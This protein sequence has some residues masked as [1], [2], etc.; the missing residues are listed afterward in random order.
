MIRTGATFGI[1]LLVVATLLACGMTPGARKRVSLPAK[2]RPYVLVLGTAQDGGLPQIGCERDC[3]RPAWNDPSAGRL[4]SSLL[5]VDPRDGKRWLI[6]ATPD[7]REQVERA[8]GHGRP[9][10]PGHRPPLFEGVFLTH[11]H[12]GHYAGLLHLGREA[13]SSQPMRVFCSQRSAAFLGA[14]A[15]WSALVENQNI[16][17]VPIAPDAPIHLAPGLSITPILVPHRDEYSDTFAFRIEGPGSSLLFVPD[18]DK[19]ERWDTPIEEAVAAVDIALLD[20]TFFD[21]TEVPGRDH[22][23]ILHP[24]ISRSLSR[25]ASQPFSQRNKVYYTHLN[26]SNP[27]AHGRTLARLRVERSGAHVAAD[28]QRFEL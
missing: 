17:L 28:G 24:L 15:P 18:I 4:V 20:G 10:G 21:T 12:M 11:L 3:C 14:E 25:F 8:R 27:A 22:S 5:I 19:W 6:D 26:H 2:P 1:A 7:I 9:V 23:E 16:T 13:Y